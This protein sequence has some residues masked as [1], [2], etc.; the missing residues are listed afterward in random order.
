MPHAP[1]VV[2]KRTVVGQRKTPPPWEGDGAG[3]VAESGLVDCVPE[4]GADLARISTDRVSYQPRE[5]ERDALAHDGPPVARLVALA[6]LGKVAE[7]AAFGRQGVGRDYRL[8]RASDD[9]ARAA[10]GDDDAEAI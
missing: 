3:R 4:I 8:E 10:I 6:P 1:R 5:I 2:Q 7:F 9:K